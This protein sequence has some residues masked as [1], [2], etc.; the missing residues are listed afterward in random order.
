MS[1]IIRLL[2]DSVANQIAAGEV[3]QRPASAVKEL[4]ENSVDSG[5]K[6]V[7]LHLRE[8]GKSL[9]QVSDDGCGMSETDARM[10]FERHATS[11]LRSADDLFNIRTLGFRGE[12][13]ASIAAVAQVELKTRLHDEDLGCCIRI[14]GA[15]IKSQEAC[16]GNA[17]TTII[18]KNLFFNIPARRKFLK[19]NN[20]E[21]RHIIE[22]FQR[23][24]LVNPEVAFHMYHN[25]KVVFQ[26]NK[27]TLKQRIVNIFGN[28]YNKRL[29]PVEINTGDV[30]ISGFI[31]HPH[32]AKKVRGEQY[33]F[34]NKRFIRSPYLNHAVENACR[35]LLPDKAF[36]GFFIYME[37]DPGSIDINIHPTKTEVKFSEEKSVYA[38]LHSS[39]KQALGKFNITPSLDF[40]E[41]VNSGLIPPK[42]EMPVRMP[43]I[44]VNPEYNPF[45]QPDFRGRKDPRT[46]RNEE[47]WDK[48]FDLAHKKHDAHFSIDDETSHPDAQKPVQTIRPDW[49][50]NREEFT[51]KKIFQFGGAYII[52]NVKSGL[53]IIDQKRAQERILFEHFLE[54]IGSGSISTQQLLF[55]QTVALSPDEFALLNEIRDE[56]KQLGFDI[57]DFGPNTINV[58]GRPHELE[59]SDIRLSLERILENYRTEKTDLNIDKKTRI[60][61]SLAKNLSVGSNKKMNEQ[62]MN[63]IIDKLFAC[64]A[65]EI[66]PSGKKIVRI[67]RKDDLFDLLT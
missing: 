26:L 43:T 38:F 7:E 51:D 44:S 49:N 29:L 54:K 52:S 55:P 48:L 41:D 20:T 14:E 50:E 40:T 59:I 3:I 60:A 6:L 11:K 58:N 10:A 31:V 27:T 13:L 18:I 56:L 47:N 24:A 23:V 61:A 9:I 42:H 33:F 46:E 17:G 30:N 65:P 12:A 64:Q 45:E 2:P 5:A 21:L 62:E 25:N 8:A 15:E 4:L 28:Q 39:V 57:A 22:E 32:H 35:E 16:A 36:P 34:C 66:S 53:M 19:S 63:H 1:D 37:V 67:L